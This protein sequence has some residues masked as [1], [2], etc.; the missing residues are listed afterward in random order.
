M[1]W[2]G[3]RGLLKAHG[4]KSNQLLTTLYDNKLESIEDGMKDLHKETTRIN[5][6]LKSLYD[7]KSLERLGTNNHSFKKDVAPIDSYLAYPVIRGQAEKS[8][9]YP[10]T[11]RKEK[12]PG[13]GKEA[14]QQR[15]GSGHHIEA[16]RILGEIKQS[17][18]RLE[19]NLEV[20]LRQRDQIR[21]YEFMDHQH[22]MD[23]VNS[24]DAQRI[25]HDVDRRIEEMAVQVK[26]ELHSSGERAQ[27]EKQKDA[28]DAKSQSKKKDG[29]GIKEKGSNARS[30][31]KTSQSR[32]ANA[33]ATKSRTNP[34]YKDRS[35]KKSEGEKVQEVESKPLYKLFQPSQFDEELLA[36]VYGRP[37]T[38]PISH[39]S[40]I[41]PAHIQFHHPATQKRAAKDIDATQRPGN[42]K[43]RDMPRQRDDDVEE[44]K[45]Q[46]DHTTQKDKSKY[47]FQPS[48]PK[49][50]RDCGMVRTEDCYPSAGD[51][52]PVAVSLGQPRQDCSLRFAIPSEDQ[53]IEPSDFDGYLILKLVFQELDVDKPTELSKRPNVAVVEIRAN[54]AEEKPRKLT[55]QKLPHVDIA[56]P[57]VEKTKKTNVYF[58]D[59]HDSEQELSTQ[60][61]YSNFPNYIGTTEVEKEEESSA[62]S[63]VDVNPGIQLRGI[64]DP[65]PKECNGPHFPPQQQSCLECHPPAAEIQS[66]LTMEEKAQEWIEQELIAR[67]VSQ[68]NEARDPTLVAQIDRN[69][70]IETS[71]V[72]SDEDNHNWI[73]DLIGPSG[74]QLFVDSGIPIDSKIVEE[75][76]RDVIAERIRILLGHPK[77]QAAKKDIAA[78]VE[79][80]VPPS[81]PSHVSTPIQTPVCTPIPSE[82]ASVVTP[83]A[84]TVSP[85]SSEQNS[86]SFKDERSDGSITEHDEIKEQ[87]STMTTPPRSPRHQRK[88][89]AIAERD[90]STPVASISEDEQK[91]TEAS[92]LATPV[93]SHRS[94]SLITLSEFERSDTVISE[95]PTPPIESS[96][97]SVAP[98]QR[99]LQ[100]LP[101]SNR[102]E[103]PKAISSKS[104]SFTVSSNTTVGSSLF[105]GISEGEHL[106]PDSVI[107]GLYSEGEFPVSEGQAILTP[108]DELDEDNLKANFKQL[109]KD[110][111]GKGDNVKTN[112]EEISE[113]ATLKDT[114][115]IAEDTTLEE[116]S[117][118]EG[119]FL[120]EADKAGPAVQLLNQIKIPRDTNAPVRTTD[121]RAYDK[122]EGEVSY[123]QDIG[124]R[125]KTKE[126]SLP[127]ESV[128]KL[129]G[130]TRRDLSSGEMTSTVNNTIERIPTFSVGE[131]RNLS[132]GDLNP[133]SRLDSNSVFA[134]SNN[135]E[136]PS[137]DDEIKFK[138]DQYDSEINGKK[139]S[140]FD[141]KSDNET[142]HVPES[143]NEASREQLPPRAIMVQSRDFDT[144]A[145]FNFTDSLNDTKMA[146]LKDFDFGTLDEQ[147]IE[148]ADESAQNFTGKQTD[149]AKVPTK[150]T[151]MIPSVADEDSS[152]DEFTIEGDANSYEDEAG[153]SG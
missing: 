108:V 131:V 60:D 147:Q 75:L 80:I 145:T 47:Y 117:I 71:S 93:A 35:K 67:I 144:T 105:E 124:A 13:I 19:N 114:D 4:G 22:K 135:D 30:R 129:R 74:L 5:E 130:L 54:E 26:Q 120:A 141:D 116:V 150:I 140:R 77:K 10:K 21:L 139:S 25:R 39:R 7:S 121:A 101:M 134:M 99:P 89:S 64:E 9:P 98:P 38:A 103:T 106:C 49:F 24:D 125:T 14:I 79:E 73:H 50:S 61:I 20:M 17:R 37:S 45:H 44:T 92:P 59:I 152:D 40:T 65:E 48:E 63:S 6:H 136:M 86:L 8:N 111:M 43:L 110:A 28:G 58:E 70:D 81:P 76:I 90:V 102:I 151:L 143:D 29:S 112:D 2:D 115:D 126:P 148:E 96:I 118:S 41:R 46:S 57:K 69:G 11:V 107:P 123:G 153:F 78:H 18:Q 133:P 88:F 84:S 104:T 109:L 12:G 138:I 56:T 83:S 62:E 34:G 142:V 82:A 66:R 42:I 72:S 36:R 32:K 137:T 100:Q 16:S 132:V 15:N 27:V 55:I 113:I 52:V 127:G 119:E 95:E 23:E 94:T 3:G 53:R 51:L 91:S 33:I 146:T 1:S 85:G 149:E 128:N 68:M 97:S 122:S 87:G 31:P